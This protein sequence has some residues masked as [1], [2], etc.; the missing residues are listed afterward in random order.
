MQRSKIG[1]TRYLV[2]AAK[3]RER[4]GVAERL[5]GRGQLHGEVAWLLALEIQPA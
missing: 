2:G 5:G 1:P 3:Q 4:E